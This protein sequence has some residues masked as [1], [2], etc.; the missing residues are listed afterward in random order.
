MA[1]YYEVIKSQD[2]FVLAFIVFKNSLYLLYTTSV[3]IQRAKDTVRNVVDLNENEVK[4]A[5]KIPITE[6]TE[7]T[8][9]I[10]DINT[11]I[12]ILLPPYVNII[13]YLHYILQQY[14][15]FDIQN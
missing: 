3:I 1:F 11:S 9:K 15:T 14:S 8:K 10:A 13:I 5:H 6:K 2:I 12:F 4:I 7:D